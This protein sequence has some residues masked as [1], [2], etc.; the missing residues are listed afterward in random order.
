M[1]KRIT[2]GIELAQL[3]GYPQAKAIC[4]SCSCFGDTT[5]ARVRTMFYN[6]QVV[7]KTGENS[8]FP[9]IVAALI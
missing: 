6:A 2:L 9:Q 8:G 1:W 5:E 7:D 3:G 4:R